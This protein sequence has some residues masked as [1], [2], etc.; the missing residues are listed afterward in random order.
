[1]TIEKLEAA[2][3]FCGFYHSTYDFEIDQTI[4]RDCEYFAEEWGIDADKIADAAFSHTDC[5]DAH[6]AIAE[7][8]CA[9]WLE[10]FS[11]ETGINLYEGLKFFGMTSP[12]YYNFETD[13]VFVKIPLTGFQQ[14]FDACKADGFKELERTIRERFTSR[15][16]FIS[17]YSN[18]LETWLEKPLT[19]WDHNELETLLVATLSISTDVCDFAS[20]VE[21]QVLEEGSGNGLFYC[22]DWA[23]VEEELR[24]VAA[25]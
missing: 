21:M 7:L 22:V 5:S 11:D 8:H 16:G 6:T 1:M 9:T 19:D 13:R 18:S 15:D 17:F 25:C 23:K 2:I 24:E 20:G 3:P 14:C 4:E 10:R 12:K